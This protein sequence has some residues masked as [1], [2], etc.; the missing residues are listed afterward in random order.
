MRADLERLRRDLSSSRHVIEARVIHPQEQP[1]ERAVLGEGDPSVKRKTPKR[2][3]LLGF[4]PG[5]G[6]LYNGEYK[7]A[8]IH[9]AV[10]I[11]LSTLNDVVPRALRDTYG[12]V[13]IVFFFYMAFDAYHTAQKK[14][15]RQ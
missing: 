1:P 11:L 8:A 6:A 9:V 10:F 7:K 4:I 15:N 3:F 14:M 5:V 2:I 12:W 13:R